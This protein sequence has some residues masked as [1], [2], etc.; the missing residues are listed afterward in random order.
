LITN[1]KRWWLIRAAAVPVTGFTIWAHISSTKNLI[2]LTHTTHF[3]PKVTL[4]TLSLFRTGTLT[5]A[6]ILYFVA[7][8]CVGTL[9][10]RLSLVYTFT[11][12]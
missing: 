8:T 11:F 6:F 4:I 5:G 1:W 12:C 9:A 2:E 7:G 10:Y 3:E